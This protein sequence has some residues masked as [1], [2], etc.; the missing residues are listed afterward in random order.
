MYE[1]D[2]PKKWS[3]D[4]APQEYIEGQL[5]AIVGVRIPILRIEAKKKMSQNQ[6]A[7]D[8]AGVKTGLAESPFER[9]RQI[10]EIIPV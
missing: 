9:D 8:R 5:R 3:I 1:S 4:H 2:R 7:Q 10:A 6:S